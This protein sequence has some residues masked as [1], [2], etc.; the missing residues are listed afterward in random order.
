M[1]KAEIHSKKQI[2]KDMGNPAFVQAMYTDPKTVYIPV[3]EL[4]GVKILQKVK[5][6]QQGQYLILE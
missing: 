6:K 2:Y 3:G 5:I 1:K 4:Y